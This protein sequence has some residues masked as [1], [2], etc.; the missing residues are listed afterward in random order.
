MSESPID[1]HHEPDRQRFT[2]TVNGAQAVRE[3][4]AVD[5][6]TLEFFH[7]FV[8]RAL[9]GGRLATRLTEH[10]LRYA[11]QQHLKVIPSCPFVAAYLARHGELRSAV[12]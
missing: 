6:G 4:R 8:P 10:A 2:S 9:R 1:I 7:T 5:A 12:S 3:Y 11:A